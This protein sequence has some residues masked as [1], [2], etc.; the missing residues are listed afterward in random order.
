MPIEH[1]VPFNSDHLKFLGVL[2]DEMLTWNHHVFNLLD[3]LSSATFLLKRISSQSFLL[4]SYISTLQVRIVVYYACFQFKIS[5]CLSILGRQQV[6]VYKKVVLRLIFHLKGNA[7]CKNYFKKYRIFTVCEQYESE[8]LE[9]ELEKAFE[10]CEKYFMI[11]C[12]NYVRYR[13]E[14]WIN[15]NPGWIDWKNQKGN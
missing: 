9:F 1:W 4:L 6:L 5:Y 11:K 15:D 7:S 2:I 13:K 14:E 8:S 3:E 12:G 10:E